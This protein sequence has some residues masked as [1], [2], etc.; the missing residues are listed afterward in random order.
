MTDYSADRAIWKVLDPHVYCVG[1]KEHPHRVVVSMNRATDFIPWLDGLK[2][3]WYWDMS[4][5]QSRT[6]LILMGFADPQ[7]AMMFKLMFSG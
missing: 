5:E 3:D 7:D 6:N 2:E 4:L 1:D